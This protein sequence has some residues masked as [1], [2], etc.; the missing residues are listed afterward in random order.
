MTPEKNQISSQL[1][2]IPPTQKWCFADA[3][4]RCRCTE[5]VETSLSQLKYNSAETCQQAEQTQPF[6]HIMSTVLC[7]KAIIPWKTC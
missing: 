2:Q 3:Q 5:L 6:I 4:G 7:V 1:L